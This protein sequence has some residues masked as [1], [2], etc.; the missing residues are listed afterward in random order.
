MDS[1]GLSYIYRRSRRTVPRA[2]HPNRTDVYSDRR[3][4]GTER[5]LLQA[6]A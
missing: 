5:G 4:V 1:S 3:I 6:L 2:G